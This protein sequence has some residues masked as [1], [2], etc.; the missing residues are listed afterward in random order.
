MRAYRFL[1]PIAALALVGCDRITGADQH[2]ILDAEAIGY[3]CRI[4]IKT[5]EDCMQENETHSPTSIL[6]GWKD[7]DK[8]VQEKTIDPTMGKNKPAPQIQQNAP[9]V[10]TSE[11]KPT[12]DKAPEN[13]AASKNEKPA[14]ATGKPDKGAA[15]KQADH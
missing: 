13:T 12:A 11:N 8:D 14:A 6:F 10:T 2:K 5:P 7:A 15:E 3:A 9:P 4:S 1:L